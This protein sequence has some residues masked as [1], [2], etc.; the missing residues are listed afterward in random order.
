MTALE[1]ELFACRSDNFGVLLHDPVTGATASIDAPEEKPI[2]AALE[3][4]GWRLSHIFTT[5]HHGDHVEA[6][7]AL[8]D[9]FGATI[10][11]PARETIPGIDRKVDGG[12]SF[13]FAGRRVEVIATPGHTVGHICFHLPEEKLLFAADTLFALGC[14]RVFEGTPA[15]MWESLS[16]LAALPDE[17]TVYFGHE[18]TLSN[19]RF[20]RTVDPE[21]AAL[22]RRA[23]EIEALRADGAFTAPTTIGIEK[24]TNPFLRAGDP[25]IRRHLGMERASDAEV[26]AEIRGRKDRF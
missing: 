4:R 13:D 16:T 6:N 25:A 26:F 3:R 23:D 24:A 10:I 18:Y 5:H 8:K 7:L 15:Q 11:G 21:N 1:I 20:A 17:T 12:D 2:L 9:R 22:A 19:A 14:G